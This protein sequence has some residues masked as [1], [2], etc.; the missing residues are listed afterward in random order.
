MQGAWRR[1][2]G[3]D[4]ERFTLVW[5]TQEL[6]GL[7]WSLTQ[8]ALSLVTHPFS[9]VLPVCP[10]PSGQACPCVQLAV[11]AMLLAMKMTGLVQAA[12]CS[13]LAESSHLRT[14]AAVSQ[15][16]C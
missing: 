3:D 13:T 2:A 15:A 1:L 14:W 7:N 4:C 10:V 8:F 11:T 5:E 9:V 6:I 12:A 16:G